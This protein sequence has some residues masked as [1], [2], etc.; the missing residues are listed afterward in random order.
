MTAFIP[1]SLVSMWRIRV[2]RVAT[3]GLIAVGI[4]TTLFWLLAIEWQLMR[5]SFAVIVG[6]E[7]G[8]IANFFLNN[9]YSFRQA[10]PTSLLARLAKFHSTVLVSFFIQWALVF[11]VEQLTTDP[12]MLLAAYAGGVLI[13]F[14][15]NYMGYKLWVW[16]HAGANA[17]SGTQ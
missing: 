4:Q 11:A 17:S 7:T 9:Y 3:M 1:S 8:L 12:H 10:A 13:G 6:T 2:V 16:K 5:P 14:A 15:F